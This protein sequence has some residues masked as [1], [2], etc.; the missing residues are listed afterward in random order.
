LLLGPLSFAADS[1]HIAAM[2]KSPAKNTRPDGSEFDG[3]EEALQP[4]LSGA[5][6]SSAGS[7]A[8]WAA[9]LAKEAELDAVKARRKAENREI[10][11]AAGKHRKKA[12]KSPAE[13]EKAEAEKLKAKKTARGTSMGAS[14]NP[15]D[16][17]AAPHRPER[18]EKSEA[19]IPLKIVSEFEPRGDQPHGH[20]R[21]RARATMPSAT[22]CCSASPARARPSP[23][24]TSSRRPSARR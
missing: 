1:A 12:G 4:K 15:R 6:V 9:D 19:G 17:A 8:D 14:T 11:S 3:F 22:R 5:P 23:W 10:R 21:T 2:A 18:P 20:C 24:P 7:I 13:A 16:R